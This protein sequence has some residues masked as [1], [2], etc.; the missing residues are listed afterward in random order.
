MKKKSDD[1]HNKVLGIVTMNN[2]HMTYLD[3]LEKNLPIP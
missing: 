1:Q 3:Q 2:I